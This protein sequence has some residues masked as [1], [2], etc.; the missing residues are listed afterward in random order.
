MVADVLPGHLRGAGQ[1]RPPP[2]IDLGEV[3]FRG[4]RWP[5]GWGMYG[6]MIPGVKASQMG[7]LQLEAK[8]GPDRMLWS[9]A[10]ELGPIAPHLCLGIP[11]DRSWKAVYRPAGVVLKSDLVDGQHVIALSRRHGGGDPLFLTWEG[12]GVADRSPSGS[13]RRLLWS[14]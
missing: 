11:G 3:L 6:L 14:S 5:R 9:M 7:H 13:P 1:L 4:A 2:G 10:V 8:Y 12:E